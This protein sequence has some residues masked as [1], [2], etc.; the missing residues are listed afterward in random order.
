MVVQH[1]SFLGIMTYSYILYASFC[2]KKKEFLLFLNCGLELHKES[3]AYNVAVSSISLQ[4]D[5]IVV[6]KSL[7]AVAHLNVTEEAKQ[8]VK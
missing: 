6:S 2:V 7:D 4:V 5:L 1:T 8:R 3:S